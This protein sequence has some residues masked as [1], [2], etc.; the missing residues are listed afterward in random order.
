MPMMTFSG[1]RKSWLIDFRNSGLWTLS[2]NKNSLTPPAWFCG[3]LT[4]FTP[5]TLT[6]NHKRLRGFETSWRLM[7]SIYVPA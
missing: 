1:V 6:T 7:S 2:A 4:G 5:Y 3:T